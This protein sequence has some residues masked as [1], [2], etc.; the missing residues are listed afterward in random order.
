MAPKKG[1]TAKSMFADI[2][3]GPDYVLTGLVKEKDGDDS[4]VM[5][6]ESGDCTHW[7]EIDEELIK[8][9][10]FHGRVPC[11]DHTHP[12]VTLHLVQPASSELSVFAQARQ[13]G[14]DLSSLIAGRLTGRLAGGA[15]TDCIYDTLLR[16]WINPK[17]GQFC[18]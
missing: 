11:G 1:F 17:T 16:R 9:F 2:G 6:S 3:K 5:L 4:V 13:R 14:A 18:D 7:T 8:S 10:D 15:S 12:L